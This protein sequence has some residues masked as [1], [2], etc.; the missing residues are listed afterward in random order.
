MPSDLRL[1]GAHHEP[2]AG[3]VDTLTPCLVS[4]RK[5]QTEDLAAPQAGGHAYCRR[6]PLRRSTQ[7]NGRTARPSRA[8]GDRC[9]SAS[10]NAGRCQR[11]AAQSRA[12]PN[13][14]ESRP[15]ENP[16]QA[17]Q[18][19]GRAVWR[20]EIDEDLYEELETV[21]L[22]ADMGVRPPC[23]CSRTCAAGHPARAERRQ[24]TQTGT[25]RIR[26]AS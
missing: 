15:V 20:Q 22:T 3:E 8:G 10:P 1:L 16:R 5:T 11:S 9:A 12:G 13:G 14:N 4:S 17:G 25:G 6:K 2:N 23:T 7:A 19:A 18:I 21:L 26:S 24:R